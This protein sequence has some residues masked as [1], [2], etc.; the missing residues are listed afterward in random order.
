MSKLPE[1]EDSLLFVSWLS[2]KHPMKFIELTKEYLDYICWIA[3]ELEK[4]LDES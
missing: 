4:M 2:V 1:N 3:R